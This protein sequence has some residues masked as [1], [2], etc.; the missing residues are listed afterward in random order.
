V[1]AFL[2]YFLGVRQQKKQASSEHIIERTGEMYP[3]LLSEIKRNLELLDNYLEKP[4]INFNFLELDQIYDEGLDGLIANHHKD[5]FL[6]VDY[7]KKEIIPLFN[8]L[9]ALFLDLYNS[10]FDAW[11]GHLRIFLPKEAVDESRNIAFDLSRSDNPY[12]VLPD[13][14]NERYNKIREKIESCILKEI[15]SIEH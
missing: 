10:M 14:L 11:S 12:C 4:Y 8:K 6:E 1:T 9:S 15:L 13:L 2:A 7:F 3:T 5:L